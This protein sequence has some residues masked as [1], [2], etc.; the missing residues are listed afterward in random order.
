MVTAPEVGIDKT[1]DSKIQGEKRAAASIAEP[2][3]AA[4]DVD[5]F[6][7]TLYLHSCKASDEASPSGPYSK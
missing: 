7:N 2:D 4:K 5:S 6:N 3:D 1:N